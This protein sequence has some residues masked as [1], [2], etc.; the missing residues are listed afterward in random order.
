MI[1]FIIVGGMRAGSTSI[2]D[3]LAQIENVYIYPRE[4]HFFSAD[5]KWSF[6]RSWYEK[7]FN[8]AEASHVV[9]EKSA[10]Y[11]ADS[12]ALQRLHQL[13]PRAKIIFVTRDP[14]KR[15]YSH[16]V[17][18]LWMDLLRTVLNPSGIKVLTKKTSLLT[19]GLEV[20]M[21]N[22]FLP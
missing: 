1:D 4:I 14:V 20:S 7:H 22:I 5:K 11:H 21:L 3:F 12:K 2:A 16:Y 19:L 10:T 9:G 18:K 8:K 13:Y 6:G 17:H 15:A